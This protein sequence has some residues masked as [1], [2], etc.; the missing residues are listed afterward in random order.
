M[1]DAF[2]HGTKLQYLEARLLDLIGG[3]AVCR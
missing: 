1:V 2:V 3:R